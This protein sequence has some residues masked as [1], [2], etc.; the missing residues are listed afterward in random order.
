[1]GV[2]INIVHIAAPETIDAMKF[3]RDRGGKVY[4]ETCPQYL[5][6]SPSDELGLLGKGM[7]PLRDEPYQRRLWQAVAD[8]T[9][10]MIGSDHQIAKRKDKIVKGG[11]WGEGTEASGSGN[12]LMG[13]IFP[14]MMSEGVNKNRISIEQFVKVCSENAAR[15]FS[16]YPQKGVLSPGSDADIIIVDPKREWEMTTES[17][18]SSSDYCM[19]EGMKVKGKV[20]R[21]FVRGELIAEDGRLIAKTPHGRYV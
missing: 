21:T 8:G 16:I 20:V 13:S 5:S 4:G 19:F 17:L 2:P 3:L 11:L 9:I 18:K 1:L 10:N 7:P 15:I 6:L 14:I 12:G